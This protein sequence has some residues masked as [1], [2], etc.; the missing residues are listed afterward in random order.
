MVREPFRCTDARWLDQALTRPA[1]AEIGAFRIDWGAADR[2][3][4]RAG[5]LACLDAIPAGEVYQACVCTQFAGTLAGDP[6]NT[7]STG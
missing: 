7:S 3:S 6:W 5:V 1:D 2:A 4:H